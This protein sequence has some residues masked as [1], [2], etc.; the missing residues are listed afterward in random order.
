MLNLSLIGKI[1]GN[2]PKNSLIFSQYRELELK[3][4]KL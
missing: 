3:S 4:S 2:R 1:S